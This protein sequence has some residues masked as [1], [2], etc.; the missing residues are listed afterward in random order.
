MTHILIKGSFLFSALICAFIGI[1]VLALIYNIPQNS[2]SQFTKTECTYISYNIQNKTNC[3]YN[4][5]CSVKPPGCDTCYWATCFHYTVFTFIQQFGY[6]DL[7][8]GLTDNTNIENVLESLYP[9][10]T[11]QLCYYNGLTVRFGL[12]DTKPALIAGIIFMALSG[13]CFILWL[14]IAI[15]DCMK[16]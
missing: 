11:T 10:N 12:S 16:K 4:C 1:F 3:P 8:E 2:N 7:F 15:Y 6:R 13:L 14:T 9:I 5:H